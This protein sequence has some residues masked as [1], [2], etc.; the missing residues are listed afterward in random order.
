MSPE[1]GTITTVDGILVGNAE[2]RTLGSGCT[3]VL[4]EEGAAPVAYVARGGWPG[5][6]DTEGT[7]PAK[8]FV[9]KQAILLTGGDVFGFDAAIGIRK[10]LIERGIAAPR[11][12]GKVPNIAGANIY[13]VGFAEVEKVEYDKL[14]Y[15]ACSRASRS[16]VPQGNVGGGTGATVGKFVGLKNAMK[17]GLGSHT[18]RVRWGVT[19]GA[20]VVVNAVGNVFDLETGNTIAGT[21]WPDREGFMEFEEY[22]AG[23]N[24]SGDKGTTIGVVATNVA[25]SHE[26]LL[27]V[28]EM[29]DDGLPRAIRPA[30]MTT[31]GDTIFA[32]STGRIQ[33]PVN[34][35]L[36][37]IDVVGHF[38]A[39]AV[40][41]AVLNAVRSAETLRGT[42][43]L[44][45][46]SMLR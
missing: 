16:V 38:A 30:H 6:F 20:L 8:T 10:Y 41:L 4:F 44:A 17:G 46:R 21:R 23:Q 7:R 11:V 24:L 19:V 27:K 13:D 39:E 34:S 12:I 28:A 32:V 33:K 31:D 9:E 35:D 14:G 45:D 3:V 25:L 18:I 15:E 5:S 37:F 2:S 22:V 29:A 42:P 40:R 43:G 1:N 36:H 26:E